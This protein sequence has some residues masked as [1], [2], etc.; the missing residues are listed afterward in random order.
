MSKIEAVP[1]KTLFF[2][3]YDRKIADGT[4]TFSKTG[5]GKDD[6]TKLCTEPDFVPDRETVER[7]IVSFRLTDEEA[8]AFR[9][10][11]GYEQE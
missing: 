7:L 4:V 10:A 5:I 3:F 2:R 11:A 9:A 8:S 1:F 6:F